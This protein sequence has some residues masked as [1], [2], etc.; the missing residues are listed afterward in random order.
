MT[1]EF[2]VLTSSDFGIDSVM[3]AVWI[4]SLFLAFFEIVSSDLNF[5]C[6]TLMFANS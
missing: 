2:S 3:L 1:E 5:I 6:E 4:I